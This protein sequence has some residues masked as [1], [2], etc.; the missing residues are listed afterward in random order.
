ML[1]LADTGFDAATD[2]LARYDLSLQRVADA[3]P[4]PGSYWGEPEAGVI[5]HRVHAR[6]DTPVHS[7]LHEACH[8]IVLPPDRRARVHTDATDSVEEEDATC[9]LQIVLADALPGVGRE[10]LM[11]DMDAW[12]YSFRLGSTRAWFEH[13]ADDARQWLA[14]RDLLPASTT[15]RP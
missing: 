5:G 6:A 12:G 1:R 14:Q 11:T 8:L 10:R 15:V 4:I 7:M 3:A 13:D 2:L 9:Y